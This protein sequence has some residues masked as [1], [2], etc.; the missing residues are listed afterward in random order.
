MAQNLGPYNIN[1]EQTVERDLQIINFY[2]IIVML[3]CSNL[4][5]QKVC[6]SVS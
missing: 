4:I 3:K 2:C 6:I 5:F 1:N